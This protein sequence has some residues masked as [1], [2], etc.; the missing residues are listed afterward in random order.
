MDLHHEFTVPSDIDTVWS[1]LLDLDVAVVAGGF[2]NVAAD[3]IDLVRAAVADS[4]VYDYAWRVRIEP[5][6]LDGRG[7]LIGAASLVLR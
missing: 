3:Y 1:T 6:G 5:T 4:A 7:P 2:A